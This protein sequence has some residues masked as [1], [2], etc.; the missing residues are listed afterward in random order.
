[1]EDGRSLPEEMEDGRSS[2][3]EME[4]GREEMAQNLA[5]TAAFRGLDQPG[6]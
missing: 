4:D 3:K 5:G 1:M 2:P 6:Y